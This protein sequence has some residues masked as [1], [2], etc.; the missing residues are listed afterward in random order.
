[1]SIMLYTS[2]L[3]ALFD[4]AINSKELFFDVHQ[5]STASVTLPASALVEPVLTNVSTN[6]T[7]RITNSVY[8]NDLLFLRRGEESLQVG[9]IIISASVSSNNR[10]ETLDP[11]VR[12]TFM[13]NP[14]R[15]TQFLVFKVYWQ[16]ISNST[17]QSVE[18]GTNTTC[19][20]WDPTADSECCST[21]LHL[22]SHS[23]I[24]CD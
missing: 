8:V 12:L 9:S 3:S 19:S 6:T 23:Y 7:I 16:F 24:L 14:V 20:F 4:E 10:S 11:P 22:L 21:T 1:M 2:Y 13:K 17:P 5:N 18:N 15:N